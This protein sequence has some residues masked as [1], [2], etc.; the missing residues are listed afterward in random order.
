MARRRPK[1]RRVKRAKRAAARQNRTT[2]RS[3]EHQ[4]AVQGLRTSA[5]AGTH[6]HQAP[7]A[8]ARRA[9]I[10]DQDR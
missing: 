8:Q 3:A 4:A 10:A 6:D 2:R 9:A 1:A 5:A 7:R